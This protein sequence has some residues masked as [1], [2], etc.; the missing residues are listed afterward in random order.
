[1]PQARSARTTS[2][3]D[4]NSHYDVLHYLFRTSV[5]VFLC[6]LPYTAF[7]NNVHLL[8]LNMSIYVTPLC[9]ALVQANSKGTSLSLP[10]WPERMWKSCPTTDRSWLTH[11]LSSTYPGLPA[12]SNGKLLLILQI[13]GQHFFP[14]EFYHDVVIKFMLVHYIAQHFTK[15]SITI[16]ISFSLYKDNSRKSLH[17]PYENKVSLRHWRQCPVWKTRACTVYV[18]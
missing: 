3:E 5:L 7:F 11:A 2:R 15:C 1:M 10:P 13:Q 14:Y 6:L 18:L 12:S 8:I 9:L 16:F 17:N 4:A